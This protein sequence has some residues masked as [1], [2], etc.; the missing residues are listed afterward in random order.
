[1]MTLK[2]LPP[3]CPADEWMIF[4]LTNEASIP[5]VHSKKV[6][7]SPVLLLKRLVLLV[8][9]FYTAWNFVQLRDIFFHIHWMLV[10]GIKKKYIYNTLLCTE[11]CFWEIAQ[12]VLTSFKKR[13]LYVSETPRPLLRA[14]PPLTH[15]RMFCR[16]WLCWWRGLVKNIHSCIYSVD[17]LK[18]LAGLSLL[19]EYSSSF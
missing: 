16:H 8:L 9:T 17:Q 3:F 15:C 2:L 11:E 14:G 12:G 5:F 7:K 10:N 13:T 1:M 4:S 18:G 6:T 19:N